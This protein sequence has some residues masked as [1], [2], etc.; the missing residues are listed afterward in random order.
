MDVTVP[1][2]DLKQLLTA[3]KRVIPRSTSLPCLKGARLTAAGGTLTI[4]A[5]SLDVTLTSSLPATVRS[6]GVAVVPLSELA[7]HVKGKGSIDLTLAGDMLR[8][9]NGTTSSLRVLPADEWP[10]TDGLDFSEAERFPLDLAAI[11]DVAIAASVDDS[12]PTLGCVYFNGAEVCATDS[13]RLH[14]LRNAEV[15][16]PKVLVPAKALLLAAKVASSGTLQVVTTTRE[17]G[18]DTI[19]E[20]HARI[21]V[22]TQVIDVLCPDDTYP[23]FRQLIPNPANYPCSI[24]VDRLGFKAVVEGVKPMAKYA[25]PIRLTCEGDELTVQART[26]DVG[27]ASGSLPVKAEG[28]FPSVVGVIAFNPEFLLDCLTTLTGDF[29]T[30]TVIDGLK[31]A[32]FAEERYR[33]ETRPGTRGRKQ[34]KV[35][36]LVGESIRLLMPV[37]VS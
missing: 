14:L 8:A 18:R 23:N 26:Q 36:T 35:G 12:K 16:Y 11:V 15:D 9:V 21:T 13:Y 7:G 4:E 37:R 5:T 29:V 34:T 2:S 1:I 20:A 25:T 31:P 17:Q 32:L 28:D 19:T 3:A 27:E 22:G 6:E 10:R 30:L 24:T 33:W